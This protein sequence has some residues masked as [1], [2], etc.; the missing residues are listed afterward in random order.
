MIRQVMPVN[1]KGHG[2]D[3]GRARQGG[4][5]ADGM[6]WRAEMVPDNELTIAP[7]LNIVAEL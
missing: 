5:I 2:G 7:A 1:D 3:G 6:G 4:R